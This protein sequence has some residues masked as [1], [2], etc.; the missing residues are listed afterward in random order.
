MTANL[1]MTIRTSNAA[2][3]AL[4]A[5][6]RSCR[7]SSESSESRPMITCLTSGGCLMGNTHTQGSEYRD[8]GNTL[9]FAPLTSSF[10][11][12]GNDIQELMK[13]NK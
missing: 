3:R 1:P 7:L 12:P 9:G 13:V 10:L 8:H 11:V 6:A 5:G 4:Q 2:T